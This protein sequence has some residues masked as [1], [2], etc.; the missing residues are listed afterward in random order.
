MEC[1]AALHRRVGKEKG[2]NRKRITKDYVSLHNRND[3]Y[4]TL[5]V[6]LLLK[7]HKQFADMFKKMS[8]SGITKVR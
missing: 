6:M 7:Q 3:T 2:E 4:K 5:Q 1:L 8:K